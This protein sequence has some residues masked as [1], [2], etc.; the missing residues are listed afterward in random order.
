MVG[1]LIG[2]YSSVYVASNMLLLMGVSK[3]DLMVPVKEGAEQE[4]LAP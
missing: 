3:E 2:T 1:V 4:E